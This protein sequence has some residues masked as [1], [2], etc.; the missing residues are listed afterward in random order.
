MVQAA[1]RLP[2]GLG[3]L[4][5]PLGGLSGML[6]LLVVLA[7]TVGLGGAGWLV[8]LICGLALNAALA[9][10]LWRDPS[11]RLTSEPLATSSKWNFW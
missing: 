7:G 2:D 8:G 5:G 6:L 9:R 10:A 3:T 4:A 11:V 1:R